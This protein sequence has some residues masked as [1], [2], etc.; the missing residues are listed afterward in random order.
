M[1]D[2][3]FYLRHEQE[4]RALAAKAKSPEIRAIHEKLAEGYADLARGAPIFA[5]GPSQRMSA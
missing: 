3:S 4:E 1:G 2:V 5:S